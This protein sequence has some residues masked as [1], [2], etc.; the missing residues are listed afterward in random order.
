MYMWQLTFWKVKYP[1]LPRLCLRHM[2]HFATFDELLLHFQLPKSY[3]Y[4][5]YY[6]SK[7]TIILGS[8][9]IFM[10]LV[11]VIT[12]Y[13][14]ITVL[15]TP[16]LFLTH[17][18]IKYYYLVWIQNSTTTKKFTRLNYFISFFKMQIA[19]QQTTIQCFGIFK[20]AN[21][22]QELVRCFIKKNMSKK[23]IK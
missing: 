5:S 8:V 18:R 21:Q 13:T 3:N 6:R 12:P 14:P 19:Y 1:N 9:V 7:I 22:Y 16:C 20:V 2:D 17:P 23:L 11:T 4:Q 15:R 10:S